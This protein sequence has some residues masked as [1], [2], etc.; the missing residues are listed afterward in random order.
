MSLL[1][2][3]FGPEILLDDLDGVK[4]K[5]RDLPPTLKEKKVYL[6]KD[7]ASIK[8]IFLTSNDFDDIGEY[9]SF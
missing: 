6:L 3:L 7:Y 4:E 9:A 2:E 8:G 1:T 5:I